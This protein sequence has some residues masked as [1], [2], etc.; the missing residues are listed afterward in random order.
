MSGMT[1]TN[2]VSDLKSVKTNI[3]NKY[4]S[5]FVL[6]ELKSVKDEVMLT[7]SQDHF[8]IICLN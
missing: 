8:F 2:S 7:N 6:S 4:V 1:H 5:F 3:A